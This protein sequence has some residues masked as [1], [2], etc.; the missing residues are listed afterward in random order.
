M[1]SPAL[2]VCVIPPADLSVDSGSTL[3]SKALCKG[4][5]AEGHN[6]WV[7]CSNPGPVME[8]VKYVIRDIG[9]PHPYDDNQGT[10][11]SV[12]LQ[13]IQTTIAGFC[14]THAKVKF[15]LV[16]CIYLSYTAVATSVI[17][18]LY[19]EIRSVVYC[20]GRIV[21]VAAKLDS[22][23]REF[24]RI[25]SAVAS[26]IVAASEDVKTVLIKDYGVDEGRLS[27]LSMP[28][29]TEHFIRNDH[30]RK[31]YRESPVNFVSVCSC[32]TD[33]KGVEDALAAFLHMNEALPGRFTYTV[34]GPDPVAGE[35]FLEKLRRFV[36]ENGLNPIVKFTGFVSHSALPQA[37]SSMDVLLDARRVGNFSSVI[38]E[39]AAARLAI[40][41]SL[42]LSNQE[43]TEELESKITFAASDSNSLAKALTELIRDGDQIDNLKSASS[44]WYHKKG[45]KF[46]LAGHI[47]DLER[48][49]QDVLAEQS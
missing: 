37:L 8:G 3:Y 4:L 31:N 14:D 41:C 16:H 20:M 43:L 6:V 5:V 26:K 48:I 15:D 2:N 23:Y 32:L 40:A 9:L 39:G 17:Q 13:S 12:F 47:K 42:V 22:R 11:S 7:I 21:N 24:V 25:G 30:S 45:P 1:R 34:M 38:L 44:D 49:Y 27:V 33:E 35:P 36:N 28:A 46:S 10:D 18:A 29:N 19:P